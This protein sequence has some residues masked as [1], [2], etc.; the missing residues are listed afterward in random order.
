MDNGFLVANSTEAEMTPAGHSTLGASCKQFR[1]FT[2]SF[3]CGHFLLDQRA[4][5]ILASYIRKSCLLKGQLNSN[6]Y[7]HL[8]KYRILRKYVHGI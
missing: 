8:F 1:A 6:V 4:G 3:L 7:T 2:C 5:F